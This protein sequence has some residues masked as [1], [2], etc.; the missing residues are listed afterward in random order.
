MMRCARFPLSRCFAVPPAGPEIRG[1]RA[2]PCVEWARAAPAAP[3]SWSMTFRS[4]ILSADGFT[5]TASSA[6]L[7]VTSRWS[8]G[9]GGGLGRPGRA[10]V[11]VDDIP[12]NDPFGG[13]VYWDRVV[14]E[15]ISD[16]EV[17]RGG[18]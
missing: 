11:L 18:G 7:S 3:S 4:T 10:L 12:L 13:W 16:V 6:R 17:V 1:R 14:R 8:A 5:G 9:G 15:S 2:S